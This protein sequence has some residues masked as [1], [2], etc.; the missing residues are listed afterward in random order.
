MI[1]IRGGRIASAGAWNG[2][3]RDIMIDRDR[4]SDITPPGAVTRD[5]ETIDAT[6]MLIIPGLINA[7]THGHGN[8]AK[9]VADRWPLETFL[10]WG[11]WSLGRTVEHYRVAGLIGA[12]EMVRK[13]C[14]AAYDLF[15]EY[16]SPSWEGIEAVANS[17][18]E[19]GMRVVIAPMM[20]DRSVYEATPG[21]IQALSPD[22]QRDVAAIRYAPAQKSIEAC[23]KIAKGWAFPTDRVK[24]ALAPTIPHHCSDEFLTGLR[25]LGREFGIG[26]HMHIAESKP[27]VM[28]AIDH[29]GKTAVIHLQNLG[30]LGPR[31]VAA[32][33]VWLDDD[34]MA[35]FADN[36]VLVA[37]NPAA[38]MKLGSGLAE[39]RR[40]MERG[41]TV[42][43]GTDGS[44]SSDNQNMFEAMRLASFT[45]RVVGREE[46][47]W[48]SAKESF[49]S[50]TVNGA[51]V[52]G[53]EGEIG[54]IKQSGKADLVFLKL[55]DFNYMPLNDA[56]AQVVFCEDGTSVDTVMI[57]GRI[58]LRNGKF[59]SFD[60]TALARRAETVIEDMRRL[61]AEAKQRAER[62]EPYVG[63]YAR[64]LTHRAYHINR[65]SGVTKQ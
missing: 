10:S 25:D 18:Q 39:V 16:P 29:Y 22:L 11:P 58:V 55:A 12:A 23:R 14:T 17:Y 60:V 47:E 63:A 34:D 7:H 65:F 15:A 6:G 30:M 3:F 44:R 32:H 21:L 59:T 45:S 36:A 53:W 62:L 38:N 42:G 41:V 54:E 1:V 19:V 5:A 49:G 4:I 50:A 20:A 64:D 48:L 56:I 51:K 8:L 33:S 2:E 43:I 26:V 46:S 24:F 61:N 52:L 35:R 28:A 31:F 57:D 27:D 13:G 9:G 37:H 40:L